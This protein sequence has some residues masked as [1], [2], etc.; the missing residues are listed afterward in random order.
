MLDVLIVQIVGVAVAVAVF[1][2][3]ATGILD[4][5]VADNAVAVDDSAIGS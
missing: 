5:T 4:V 2:A 3:G 1:V